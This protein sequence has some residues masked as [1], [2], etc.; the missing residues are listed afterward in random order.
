MSTRTEYRDRLIEALR[1]RDEAVALLK[2]I[3]DALG[4]GEEGD[5]L[6]AVARDSYHA[7]ME[8]AAIRRAQQEA[9]DIYI[10]LGGR[11]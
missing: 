9:D 7:E 3:A 4:T 5:N 1:Q 6:V 11:K 8:L 2:R 10:A